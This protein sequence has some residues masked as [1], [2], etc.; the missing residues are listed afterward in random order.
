MPSSRQY[1]D[2]I[3]NVWSE[4]G[5]ADR[6]R[7][8]ELWKGFEQCAAAIYQKHV[9]A[10]FNMSVADQRTWSDERWLPYEFSS[11]N[12]IQQ[13]A[14]FVSHEDI[15]QGIN[16]YQRYLIKFSWDNV[17]PIEVDL[18]GVDPFKTGIDEIIA[19]INLEAGRVVAGKDSTGSLVTFRSPTAGLNSRLL[20]YPASTPS[21]DA[22]EFILG[23]LPADLPVSFPEYPHMYSASYPKVH[24]VPVLQDA[25]REETARTYLVEGQDYTITNGNFLFKEPPPEKMWAKRSLF[26]EEWPYNNFGFLID[27]YQKNSDRYLEIVKG[28]WF[29]FWTGPKPS[30]LRRALYLLF[31]L[32]TAPFDGT[33]VKVTAE[34][35]HVAAASG[36]VAVYPVPAGLVPIVTLGQAVRQFD[37]LVDGID[38]FDKVNYPGFLDKEVGRYGIQRFLLDGATKGSNPDTDESKALRMLEEYTFL[39]QI[40]VNAFVKPDVNLRSV[41]LFLDAIKPAVKAYLFQVIVGTF[42]DELKFSEHASFDAFID[43]TPNVDSNET[44]FQPVAVLEAHEVS[45]NPGLCVDSEVFLLQESLEVVVKRFGNELV[46]IFEA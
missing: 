28:L 21:L 14:T 41:R 40:S 6:D 5:E 42:K 34:E 9:E 19:K 32:P 20:F 10:N 44:T 27:I 2:F 36:A 39:P 8:A 15:S 35:V 31:E 24:S 4:L 38:I 45:V 26:D 11:V 33:V 13:A 7:M 43:V 37:P 23:L 22:S 46:E 16:L 12:S 25:V 30:N 1:F 3:A 18:R 17:S 29:A